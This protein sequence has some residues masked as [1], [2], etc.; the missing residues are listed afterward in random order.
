MTHAL[1]IEPIT[2]LRSGHRIV[3]FIE[4]LLLKTGLEHHVPLA[5]P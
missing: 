4:R 3:L 1:P 2:G 5:A